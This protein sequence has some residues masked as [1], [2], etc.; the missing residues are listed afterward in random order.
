MHTENITFK[1]NQF[2]QIITG[3]LC[4][5]ILKYFL[6][7]CNYLN[8]NIGR[9]IYAPETEIW[10]KLEFYFEENKPLDVNILPV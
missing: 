9:L 5:L 6:Q 1:M 3:K 4:Q 7:S 2:L 8:T 10:D